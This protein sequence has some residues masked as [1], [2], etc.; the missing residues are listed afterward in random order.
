MSS[1]SDSN[2]RVRPSTAEPSKPMPSAKASSS[3]PGSIEIDFRTPATSVNHSLM[4]RMFF[5]ATSRNT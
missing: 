5:C 3:S 1:M 2:T 4:K